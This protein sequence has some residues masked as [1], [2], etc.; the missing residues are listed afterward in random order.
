MC[1]PSSYLLELSDFLYF[2]DLLKTVWWV[3][4]PYQGPY[5]RSQNLRK[6]EG[7]TL[8]NQMVNRFYLTHMPPR[9]WNV[10]YFRIEYSFFKLT[11]SW[12]CALR[13]YCYPWLG[14]KLPLMRAFKGGTTWLCISRGIGNTRDKTWKFQQ[15]AFL[16]SKFKS[17][18]I[19]L[20]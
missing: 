8:Y 6:F 17:S 9:I 4:S 14:S 12:H 20:S 5:P 13:F 7:G 16:L 11:G 10:F 15:S 3:N 18:N 2:L 19:N 1:S